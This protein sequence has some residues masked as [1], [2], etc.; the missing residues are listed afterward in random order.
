MGTKPSTPIGAEP[1]P[2]WQWKKEQYAKDQ[3][4]R[5][6]HS[7]E[8]YFRAYGWYCNKVRNANGKG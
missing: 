1:M 4:T 6:P 3:A 8:W 2:F 5:T 7:R